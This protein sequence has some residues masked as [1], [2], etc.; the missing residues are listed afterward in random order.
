MLEFIIVKKQKTT[1]RKRSSSKKSEFLEERQKNKD[2]LKRIFGFF[3][4]IIVFFLVQNFNKI[5]YITA[6]NFF[7]KTYDVV[8]IISNNTISLCFFYGQVIYESLG[9]LDD[10][11]QGVLI[12][13]ELLGEFTYRGFSEIQNSY[14]SIFGLENIDKKLEKYFYSVSGGKEIV[15][16]SLKKNLKNA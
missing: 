14:Q 12:L 3:V 7:V 15:I 6:E 5:N 16:D 8:N 4:L 10:M 13:Y 9:Q 1:S 2:F 11:G